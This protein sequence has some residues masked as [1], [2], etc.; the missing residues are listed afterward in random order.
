MNAPTHLQAMATYH[1]SSVQY[2]KRNTFPHDNPNFSIFIYNLRSHILIISSLIDNH[3]YDN[4]KIQTEKHKQFPIRAFHCIIFSVCFAM[5]IIIS[6]AFGAMMSAI[7]N[8]RAFGAF[9]LNL[10]QLCTS[11]QQHTR[12]KYGRDATHASLHNCV[13]VCVCIDATAQCWAPTRPL[14]HRRRV[15]RA[16]TRILYYIL[17]SP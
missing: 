10:T 14:A 16:H 15:Q 2:S 7:N 9:M 17:A 4:K 1:C 8:V 5:C 12:E 3:S 6:F 11:K 13:T